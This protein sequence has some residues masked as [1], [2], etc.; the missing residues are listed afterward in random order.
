MV[1]GF[2]D[3]V[4]S[5]VKSKL[6]WLAIIGGFTGLSAYLLVDLL[7]PVYDAIHFVTGV[8]I[9][10]SQELFLLSLLIIV[11]FSIFPTLLNWLNHVTHY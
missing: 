11:F 7:T 10:S 4:P 5:W 8:H 2:L 9:H 3:V 6:F 1:F